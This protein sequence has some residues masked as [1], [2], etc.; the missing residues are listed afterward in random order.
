MM[1]AS[2]LGIGLLGPGLEG[3][4]QSRAILAGSAAWDHRAIVVPAPA[5][6]PATE[7]RRAGPV[8]RLALAVATE[9]TA[10]SALPPA[11]LRSVFASA[12]GDGPTVGAVL[13]AIGAPGGFVSPTQFHNSVHNAAAGYWSIGVGSRRPATCLGCHDQTFGMAL[14]KAMAECLTER[15][16]VLMVVYDWPFPSPLAAARPIGEAFG[17]ALVLAPDGDGPRLSVDWRAGAACIPDRQ[18]VFGCL[19]ANPAARALPLLSALAHDGP[20]EV[21]VALLDGH[22]AVAVLG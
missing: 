17:M 22:L 18:P 6:L 15:E 13:E 7:R 5:I 3:W 1:Q 16:P 14:M 19:A 12:N 11:G 4:A 2:V 8:T 9:A 10:A 21:D 20:G